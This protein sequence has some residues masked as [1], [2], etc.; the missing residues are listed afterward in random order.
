MCCV[1]LSRELLT[2]L[3]YADAI[4]LM[5]TSID[6]VVLT[7]VSY[8]SMAFTKQEVVRAIGVTFSETEVQDAKDVLWDRCQDNLCDKPD[9]RGSVK[10]TVKM[11]HVQ[12]I[13]DAVMDL[14][15][16]SKMPRC[17]CDAVGMARWPIFNN[18]IV[19][20]V[21]YNEQFKQLRERC[22]QL[23]KSVTSNT[24]AIEGTKKMPGP[25]SMTPLEQRTQQRM[26]Q[27]MK[28]ANK[29]ADK[30]GTDG[31][32]VPAAEQG[33]STALTSDSGVADVVDSGSNGDDKVVPEGAGDGG[34][35]CG[36]TG[37]SSY[38]AMVNIPGAGAVQIPVLTNG[39]KGSEPGGG[40][41]FQTAT[42]NVVKG[43][44]TGSALRGVRKVNK[45]SVKVYRLNISVTDKQLMEHLTLNGIIG[46]R[47]RRVSMKDAPM[48]TYKVDVSEQYY[49]LICDPAMWDEY[50]CVSDWV[51][52][53]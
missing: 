25:G 11:A 38:A 1:G 23:E 8:G 27:M 5:E 42:R 37:G 24:K 2:L 13:Y 6:N 51:F 40:G 12:D 3:L 36:Q 20:A 45:R 4:V 10:R 43:S 41:K 31:T 21:N 16:K 53:W 7:Y 30:P 17:V 28:D 52:N 33:R 22:S 9:R 44:A 39:L 34:G 50:I 29:T 35:T 19:S 46:A 47:I 26:T 49:E 14:S 18:T 32:T 15:N 48:K